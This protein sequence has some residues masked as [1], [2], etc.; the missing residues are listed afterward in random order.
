MRSL[1][2]PSSGEYDEE[3]NDNDDPENEGDIQPEKIRAVGRR[4]YPRGRPRRGLLIK[5][6]IR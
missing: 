2:A 6:A 1:L 5:R 4:G 3:D